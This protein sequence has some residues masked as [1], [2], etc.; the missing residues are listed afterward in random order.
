MNYYFRSTIRN[1]KKE[2]TST[3]INIGGL[4]IGITCFIILAL[5]VADELG[6]DSFHKNADNTYRIFVQS[7]INGKQDNNTK[8]SGLLGP[9]L[10]QKF[11]EVKNYARMSYFGIRTFMYGDKRLR[12]GRIYGA[13]SSFFEVFTYKFISGNPE[14]ALNK[15][16]S[17]VL[18]KTAAE[19]IFGKE[20]ALGKTLRTEY[21]KDFLVT[22][23][24][25]DFPLNSSFSCQMLES[26]S[27][28]E[29]NTNWTDL[30][31]TTYVQL[32]EGSDPEI[33]ENKL[34]RIIT[35]NMGP[36]V[37]KLLGVSIEQFL[38]MGNEYRLCLQPVKSIYLYSQRSYGLDPNTE[39]GDQKSGDISYVY[40]FSAVAVFILL[41]AV[42]NFMNL[43]TARSERRS[44]EVGIRKTLGSDR[45]RLIL[46]FI[47][48]AV[49]I[50]ALAVVA[51]LALVEIILPL[52]NS[53]ADKELKLQYFNYYTVPLVIL[54]IL[55]VGILSG[56]Y[57]AFYLSSFRPVQVLKTG[58]FQGKRK[59]R[60]RSTLVVL[61]FSISIILLT[62]T[63]IIKSQM[64]YVQNKNL[65]FRKDHLY[66]ISNANMLGDKKELFK[67]EISKNPHVLSSTVCS[68]LFETGIPGSGYLYNKTTGTDPMLCQV[69]EADYDFLKTFQIKMKKGTFFSK[70]YSTD[71]SA[72]IVNEAAAK[73]F[74]D[75]NP[76]GKMI[77]DLDARTRGKQYKIIGVISNFNYESLHRAVRPIVIHVNLSWQT[78][79]TLVVRVSGNNVSETISYINN[80]WKNY[81]TEEPPYY[82]FVDQ[83]L[84]QLYEREEKTGIIATIFTGLAIFIA[85]LGLFGL[86]AFITEQ[87]TKEI[88]IR[89]VLG[90]SIS[91]IVLL[92][93]K[94]F[95]VW[96]VLANIIA[97]PAAF[98]MM[99]EWL[100]NFAY[101]I[102]I[103]P[104]I[105]IIAGITALV[106]ALITVGL[107][108]VKAANANPVNSLKYE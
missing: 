53:L 38:Q 66:S 3:L 54:F 64:D 5:Y 77:T 57:P 71:S 30:W 84:I 41:L 34:Q 106:I 14:T 46:Q 44:K 72:V 82:E 21:G 74:N 49:V 83:Q 37:E 13:D 59:S 24:M 96:V 102:T 98:Y 32:K 12:D 2:K 69:A 95:A 89:K 16:Y 51:A 7:K 27:T 56:S 18:T 33:F 80:A 105:F 4:A 50:T 31:Y 67:N 65:G 22:G 62:G 61:Q 78:A 23:V 8:T 85:C 87:R 93:S 100:Q 15:P 92:L 58:M 55:T 11:P 88:G 1:I 108:T 81:V 97:I 25:E 60:L 29:E 107:H 40:I 103:G 47:S 68:R 70:S 90:A 48:E 42:I 86:A 36:S 101:R 75:K 52:F 6:Y 104:W 94:E 91:E 63:I 99:Q 76:V 28:Y 45:L 35:E 26:M 17:V 9:L 79:R 19:R 73:V 43:A 10:T 20:D 39:W